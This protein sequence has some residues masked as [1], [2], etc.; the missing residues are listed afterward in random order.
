LS[1]ATSSRASSGVSSRF[2]SHDFRSQ[3][4]FNNDRNIAGGIQIIPD[5]FDDEEVSGILLQVIKN[6]ILLINHL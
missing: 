2:Q 6:A 4:G 1:R 5:G 3:Q